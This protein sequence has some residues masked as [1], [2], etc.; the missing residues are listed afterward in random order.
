M[1]GVGEFCGAEEEDAV[2]GLVFCFLL[3]CDTRAFVYRRGWE[4]GGL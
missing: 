3:V 2:L 4:K 1:G